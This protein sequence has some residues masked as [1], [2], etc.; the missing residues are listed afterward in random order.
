MN[1]WLNFLTGEIAK[2]DVQLQQ[3]IDLIR[4]EKYQRLEQLMGR[5]DLT[6]IEELELRII[7]LELKSL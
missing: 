7:F 4:E 2:E 1:R 3:K 5:E 6:P